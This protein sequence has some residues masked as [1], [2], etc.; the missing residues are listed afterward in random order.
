M[1]LTVIAAL[2]PKRHKLFGPKRMSRS[3]W[4]WAFLM[5][6]QLTI[7]ASLAFTDDPTLVQLVIYGAAN[8]TSIV[9]GVTRAD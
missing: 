1:L 6:V 9:L 4:M 8:V 7:I 2:V 3:D 5:V